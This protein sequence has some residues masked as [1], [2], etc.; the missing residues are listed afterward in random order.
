MILYGM[1]DGSLP[2][3]NPDMTELY[4]SIVRDPLE[5]PKNFSPE[6]VSVLKAMLE[7]DP[8]KRASMSEVK[9]FPYFN[10]NYEPYLPTTPRQEKRVSKKVVRRSYRKKRSDLVSQPNTAAVDESTEDKPV[11]KQIS[12][13]SN[14]IV[15]V[16]S[17]G[18]E[19]M[20]RHIRQSAQIEPA[21]D[22]PRRI[23]SR[24]GQKSV[25][26]TSDLPTIF[27][28]KPESKDSKRK[29][30]PLP[31]STSSRD[32][33][34]SR[35]RTST[36]SDNSTSEMH[37]DGVQHAP[38]VKVTTDTENDDDSDLS[39]PW[40]TGGSRQRRKSKC[41]LTR[42]MKLFLPYSA[43]FLHRVLHIIRKEY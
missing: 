8:A 2:F 41:R 16:A 19:A 12:T 33:P 4:K 39:V 23:L 22:T 18:V 29:R 34:S 6:F 1:L 10:V 9:D 28:S 27:S 24:L 42:M 32:L 26:E 25:R 31:K 38:S 30:A 17:I 15:P 36:R 5:Y 7:K 3:G 43:E 13:E 21:E 40:N 11:E 20:E 14:V 37:N 35:E